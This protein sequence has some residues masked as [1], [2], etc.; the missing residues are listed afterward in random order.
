M[1]RTGFYSCAAVLAAGSALVDAH[2]PS[3]RAA[4]EVQIRVLS[5]A[6]GRGEP[7]PVSEDAVFCCSARGEASLGA[8]GAA[9]FGAAPK[10]T[11]IVVNDARDVAFETGGPVLRVWRKDGGRWQL[12]ARYFTRLR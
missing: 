3:G 1:T 8:A 6:L 7:V 5:E 11:R 12:E 2:P 10:R 9:K 4:D